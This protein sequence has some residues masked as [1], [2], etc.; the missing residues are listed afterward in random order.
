[1]RLKRTRLA[2]Q[3]PGSLCRP[4]DEVWTKLNL[5][6]LFLTCLVLG[7]AA[8]SRAEDPADEGEALTP[9]GMAGPGL[10]ATTPQSTPS[11]PTASITSLARTVPPPPA[12]LTGHLQVNV[13]APAA[14]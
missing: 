14:K 1:M 6:L 10:P 5:I 7:H 3:I 8:P 12:P 13:N 9:S 11:H 4:V 2:C